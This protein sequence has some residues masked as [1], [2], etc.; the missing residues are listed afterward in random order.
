MAHPCDLL[1]HINFVGKQ[2]QNNSVEN[3]CHQFGKNVFNQHAA[4]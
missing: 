1:S 3:H 4:L 2:I